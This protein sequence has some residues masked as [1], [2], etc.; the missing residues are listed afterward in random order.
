VGPTAPPAD[1]RLAD[2]LQTII[3]YKEQAI[4]LGWIKDRGIGISLDAKLNAAQASLSRGDNRA[5][6]NQLSALLE[7][8]D[9]QAGKQLSSEAV[10]L[11]K[12][13]T[14]YLISRML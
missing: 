4:Q 12:F 3:S 11:L 5:A 2:F 13:N 8:V 1:F 7:E 10:A 6:T 9:A 14:Q